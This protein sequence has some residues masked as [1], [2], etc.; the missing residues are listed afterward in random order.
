[1]VE[2]KYLWI[3]QRKVLWNSMKKVSVIIPIYNVENYIEECLVSA[4]NQTLKDIEIICVDDGTKDSSM[5]IV[6]R[7][8]QKDDRIVIIHREN[9]GLSAA[10][11][12]GLEAATGEYVYFLDSD[13]YITE[14]MLEILYHE[15]KKDDLDNIYFDAESFYE[16]EEVKQEQPQYI[17]YYRRPAAFEQVM[18]GPELYATMENLNCYRPSA[19]LQML[20]RSLLLDQGITFYEGIVHEDQLFT[21]QAILVAKRA[22]HIDIPFYKRRVRAGSIMTA[23]KEFQSS[24]GYFVCLSQIKK[25]VLERNYQDQ[26]LMRALKKRMLALQKLAAKDVDSIPYEELGKELVNH[27]LEEQIDYLMWVRCLAEIRQVQQKQMDKIRHDM[28]TKVANIKKSTT[29]RLGKKILFVPQKTKNLVSNIRYKGWECTIEGYKRK[30]RKE[31]RNLSPDHICVSV[32]IPMYNARKYL[33]ECLDRLLMQ[34]LQSIE[35]ICVNDGST[36]ATLDLLQEYEKKD[37]R[38]RIVNQENQGAGVARNSGM[39]VAQGEYYLFLDADDIFHV[40]L[41]E[42][43][44]YKAKYDNADIVLFQAFRYNVQTCKKEEM[45]WVLKEQLLPK[46][47]PFSIKD[48]G[49]KIYQITTACPWSKMF[50]ADFVKKQQL[51]FQNVKNANDVFFVRTALACAKRITVVKKRLITYRFNDGS[52]LQSGKSK[53]PLEFYKAFKALKEELIRR[54]LYGKVE[55]SYVNMVLKESLFNL[56]TTTDETAQMQIANILQSEGFDYFEFGKYNKDFYYDKKEYAQYQRLNVVERNKNVIDICAA[57]FDN[58]KKKMWGDYHYALAIKKAFEK[59]GYRANIL[60]R[61]HWYEKSDA[62]YVIVLRGVAEYTPWKA[63]G[64]TYIMWNISHPADVTIEEYNRYDYVFFASE[65]MKE[66]L[67]NQIQPE[68]GVLMQCMDPRVMQYVDKEEKE[69]ELLFVG[70]SR[71]VYRQILRDLLPTEHKLTV[72]GWQWDAFPVKQYVVADHIPNEQVGQAYH[73]AKILLNDHWDDMKEYG[74]ISNRI[75]DAL[76]V[77]AFV[78]SDEVTGLEEL[79]HGAVV[80]Y[81]DKADLAEKID[82]YLE[83][84]TERKEKA[85]IGQELVQNQHTFDNR[86]DK[87]IQVLQRL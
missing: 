45:N 62:Q 66:K 82:Y 8:A 23:S 11:N 40:N 74:I 18:S 6:E 17:H 4:L 3:K 78:I 13:D 81:R 35:I 80:T 68:S 77:G 7:Y 15:C 19:C 57:M 73:D 20:R 16:S 41:C 58:D 55:K 56:N 14:D 71:G 9:G 24:Y 1:M 87:M 10:R 33:R 30:M 86:V 42:E 69:Y 12:T 38:I 72:Y 60:T 70:N 44:Y 50:R 25:L 43:A 51:T 75:F 22:K 76:A 27:P 5:E 26:E 52:N 54:K 59:R 65:R 37:S 79:F 34:T 36:D 61:E 39:A 47:M 28:T 29:F 21:I 31:E 83:H 84:E 48:A 32:I 64:Q 85:T 67:G 63:T 46:H 53:A 49:D 2:Y